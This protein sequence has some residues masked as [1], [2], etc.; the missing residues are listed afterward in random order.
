MTTKPQEDAQEEWYFRF[1]LGATQ[2]KQLVTRKKAA[3]LFMLITEW[4]EKN[5]FG[6][7]GS[8]RPFG[9]DD[10]KPFVLRKP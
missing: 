3:E 2:P 6:I 1:G 9:P 5:D 8:F 4:A 10:L 7:G